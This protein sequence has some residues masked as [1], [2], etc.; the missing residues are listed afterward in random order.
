MT[1]TAHPQALSGTRVLDLT[2]LL[3]GPYATY[4]LAGYGADVVKVEDTGAGDYARHSP[5]LEASDFGAAFTASNAGKRSIAIDLKTDEGRAV[6]RRMVQ[7]ADVL[8]ESFRP[9][10]MHRLGL[11]YAK[12]SEINPALV[13]CA[14]S[15]YG[16]N[17]RRAALAGHD[18]NYQ[19]VAGLLSQRVEG[20]PEALPPAL[21]GDL[22]GGSFSAVIAIMA[23]L[24]ERRAS[25]RG[26][27]IDISIGHGAMALMPL[28][29]VA[30]VNG[31]VVKPFGR[32]ALSGGNPAYGIYVASDGRRVALGALEH[33]FWKT[34]C[35]RTG[36]DDLA[37][38][39]P[40][41]DDAA[42]AV[43]RQRLETLFRSRS[44]KEWETLGAQW[45]VCLTATAS[46]SEALDGARTE[47]LPVFDSYA[48]GTSRGDVRVEVLKGVCAD[49][50]QMSRVL[51]PPPQ[52]GEYTRSLM[53]EAGYSDADIA[54]YLAAGI[55]KG[56]Q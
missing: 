13:Y 49:L 2:R 29:S 16:Q 4:I 10:V 47:G 28:V 50:T 33:K 39:R 37:E 36:L 15:G 42:A 12:L 34:F 21:L 9:G 35:L 41:G 27:F 14:I 46:V 1:D 17:T 19:G 6:F 40:E 24:L 18:L 31:E 5:P 48:R 43:V 54:A 56:P 3:P 30:A 26:R 25:G 38:W 51:T 20:E 55:V 23:A 8:V 53:S 22:V 11:D 52:Q 7:G 45:D 32:T 44:A